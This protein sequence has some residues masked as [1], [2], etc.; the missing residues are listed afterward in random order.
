MAWSATLSS[1]TTADA[2]TTIV[3]AFTNGTQSFSRAFSFGSSLGDDLVP[4][5]AAQEVR[6]LND[7]DAKIAAL[8][9]SIGQPVV[10]YLYTDPT[11]LS[12]LKTE[13][14]TN[15]K[16]MGYSGKTDTQVAALLNAMTGVGAQ[17]V[18]LLSTPKD[19]F[20]AGT[21]AASIRLTTG[22]GTDG[23]ALAPLAV[24]KWSAVLA[25]AKAASSQAS[26]DLTL[27]S[28]IGDPVA[29]KVMTDAEHAA[30]LTRVGSRAEVV[31]SPGF[32]VTPLMVTEARQ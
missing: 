22:V 30:L 9:S 20:L 6:N 16:S 3:L 14:S 13:I 21:V 1:T 17:T 7:R 25:Q 15:P 27:L 31:F 4:K 23:A 28:A 18:T 8:Q 11:T 19:T 12:K 2:T 26:I 29:D 24:A 32:V 10:P 5:L